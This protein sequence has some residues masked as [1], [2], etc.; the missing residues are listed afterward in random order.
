MEIKRG[1]LVRISRGPHTGQ[2][3]RVEVVGWRKEGRV[4]YGHPEGPVTEDQ[5]QFLEHPESN[6][7]I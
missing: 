2:T 6:A 5:V 1:S 7:N 4:F 3:F